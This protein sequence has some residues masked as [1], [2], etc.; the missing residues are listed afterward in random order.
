MARRESIIPGTIRY[1]WPDRPLVERVVDFTRQDH[2]VQRHKL[3]YHTGF[4]RIPTASKKPRESLE[5]VHIDNYAI[6]D[7]VVVATRSGEPC[8]AVIVAMWYISALGRLESADDDDFLD[9][10]RMHILVHKFLS[11]AIDLPKIRSQ[12]PYRK[13]RAFDSLYLGLI[14]FTR[15]RYTTLLIE[16]ALASNFG[17][18]RRPSCVVAL[19][20]LIRR[21]FPR[22]ALLKLSGPRRGPSR[23]DPYPQKRLQN[24]TAHLVLRRNKQMQH[25]NFSVYLPTMLSS[26]STTIL[27]GIYS[28]SR[29]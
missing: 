14:N 16:K 26:G 22:C 1:A 29:R 4:E 11:P 17:L 3:V 15:K 23:H 13:V 19:Y 20:L 8:I 28:E 5:G 18:P 21:A 6:G 25:M 2:V 12:R 10:S 27:H 9:E 24:V 7:T